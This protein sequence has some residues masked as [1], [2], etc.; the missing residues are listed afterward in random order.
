MDNTTPDNTTPDSNQNHSNRGRKRRET[1]NELKIIALN[2][3][4]LVANHR[5]AELTNTLRKHKPH[6]MLISET[7][8]NQRH[9]MSFEGYRMTRVDRLNAN[10]GGG[11]AII[12]RENI[13]HNPIA[14]PRYKDDNILKC[15]GIELQMTAP[16]KLYIISVYA[17]YSNK[18]EFIDELNHLFNF[19]KLND[20]NVYY[21]IAGDLNARHQSWGD[22]INNKRGRYLVNW[23][24]T[25]TQFKARFLHP[26]EPT[27]T[28]TG[29]SST[30]E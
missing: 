16:G 26:A 10:Q 3:N 24:N 11:T 5:R 29:S 28:R 23:K 18:Q 17:T 19:L 20:P 4:S 2:A 27:Y 12:I 7:K 14:I 15:T 21:I 8:L 9:H 13:P 1:L 22:R 6:I 25:V 30:W